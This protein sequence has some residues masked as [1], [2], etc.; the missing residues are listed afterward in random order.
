MIA[1]LQEAATTGNGLAQDVENWKQKI[2]EISIYLEA[3]GTVSAGAVQV[4]TALSADYTG[5]WAPLGSPITLVTNTTK[6]AQFTGAFKA[7]RA[8]IST[9]ITGGAV[10]NSKIVAA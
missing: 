8:R 5:T 9:N 3:V 10:L 4:E 1:V 6:V 7:V 2:T